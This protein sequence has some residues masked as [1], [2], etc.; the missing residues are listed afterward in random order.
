MTCQWLTVAVAQCTGSASH[1]ESLPLTRSDSESGAT[2]VS[3]SPPSEVFQGDSE[4]ESDSEFESDLDSL[5]PPAAGP[6][7]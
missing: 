5:A 1:G 4:S 7:G 2:P 6:A 3:R